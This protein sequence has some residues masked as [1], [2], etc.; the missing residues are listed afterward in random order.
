[1]SR[2]ASVFLE[3]IVIRDCSLSKDVS[4][5]SLIDVKCDASSDEA[6]VLEMSNVD[7]VN[8]TNRGGSV[9]FSVRNRACVSVSMDSVVFNGNTFLQGLLFGQKND[10]KNIGL[11][12]NTHIWST[13]ANDGQDLTKQVITRL[14]KIQV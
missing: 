3:D 10:L 5:D 11:F 7:I 1:M 4:I 13:L 6:F 8:N 14:P 2:N 9:G 12:E